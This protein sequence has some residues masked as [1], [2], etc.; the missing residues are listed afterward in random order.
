MGDQLDNDFATFPAVRRTLDSYTLVHAGLGWRMSS[1][2]RA[3]LQVENL[4]DTDYEDI[5]GYRSPGARAM[6]GVQYEP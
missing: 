2:L 1:R 5:L 4:F 6:A 3:W